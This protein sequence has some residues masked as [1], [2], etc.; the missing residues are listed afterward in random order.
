MNTEINGGTSM[1]RQLDFTKEDSTSNNTNEVPQNE[2]NVFSIASLTLSILSMLSFLLVFS[3]DVSWLFYSIVCGIFGTVFGAC[4]KHKTGP[5][6]NR[7]PTTGLFGLIL[8]IIMLFI[9]ALVILIY[10]MMISSSLFYPL[11]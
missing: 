11:H 3:G 7:R 6:V 5:Y 1:D 4:C 2:N 10:I 8:S 9:N